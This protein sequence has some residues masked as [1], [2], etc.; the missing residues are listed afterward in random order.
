[1]FDIQ[2][3]I[4]E[5]LARISRVELSQSEVAD[6]VLNSQFLFQPRSLE[7]FV[8]VFERFKILDAVTPV[9]DSLWKI[10][11]PLS[12]LI[13][14]YVRSLEKQCPDLRIELEK[15]ETFDSWREYLRICRIIKEKVYVQ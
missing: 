14:S 4:L 9:I 13:M 10:S 12:S 3:T 6:M 15:V 1:M 11:S 2:K 8:Y 5:D 7:I